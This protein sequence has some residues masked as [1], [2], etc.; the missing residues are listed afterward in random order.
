MMDF[1]SL[2]C[3]WFRHTQ[4]RDNKVIQVGTGA[5]LQ[6]SRL[7]QN[8]IRGGFPDVDAPT[9]KLDTANYE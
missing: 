5:D 4:I 1:Y 2:W 8:N 9:L 7:L 6:L 3:S